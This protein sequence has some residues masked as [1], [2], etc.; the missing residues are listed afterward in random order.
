VAS[1]G[2]FAAH[3]G[4]G[5]LITRILGFV[6]ERVFAHYFGDGIAADAYRAALKIPNVIRNLLGE[7]TLSASFIPVYAR[8]IERGEHDDARRLAG[9]IASLL[10]A[11]AAVAAIAGVLLAPIITDIAAPG[12]DGATRELTV[13]LVEIMFPMAGVLILSA[14]CL[15]I[16]NT[17][18]QF[19]LSYAAPAMWNI[20]QIATLVVFGAMLWTETR[21]VVALAWG[22]L[23]G[24]VAQL[25][26]QLPHTLRAG[27]RVA[28]GIDLNAT[29]VRTVIHAWLPVVFG[30]G[31]YQISS[32]VDTALASFLEPGAVAIMGYAQLI[33]ILPVSLF[34]A[35]IAA[36]ALPELSRDAVSQAQHEISVQLGDAVRRL[37]FF[38]IPAAVGCAVLASNLVG[39]LFQTGAFGPQQTAIAAGVLAAYS[40]GIPAQASVKL[41]ASG[42]YALGD[43]KTPV[44][45]AIVSVITSAGVA[46]YA[47]QTLGP[48]GI[49]LGAAVGGN[50]NMMLNFT[51]LR[52]RL[53]T[54][55]TEGHLRAIMLG[56]G[57]SVLAGAA[58]WLVAGRLAVAASWVS[59]LAAVAAFALVY[60]AATVVVGH[61]EARAILRRRGPTG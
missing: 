4:A 6:R 2:R 8:M 40:I 57:S 9:V 49:A 39:A 47:M 37:A 26:V 14:W 51:F 5:I 60:G 46:L 33:A 41:L 34:G 50:V 45:I 54:I 42:H 13:R 55:L 44:R 61:P 18:R 27:G 20:V 21:L 53:G 7:G 24:S 58:A 35:S 28:W 36:V 29:G 59:A 31:V 12:F 56:I 22:A 17:H 48:A 25:V 15:G 30:A 16:L 32:I 43:T 23:A 52:R 11:L 10:V 38:V 19:F 3:V 1:Q